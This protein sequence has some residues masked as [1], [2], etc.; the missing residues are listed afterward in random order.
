MKNSVKLA[1]AVLAMALA[2]GSADA[3]VY[4]FS[5]IGQ[6]NFD[7]TGRFTTDAS[8]NITSASGT[9]TSAG[10][11]ASGAF[12]F[13]GPGAGA[14][15]SEDWSNTYNSTSQIFTGN[16]LGI[17]ISGQFASLYNG[18]SAGYSLCTGT[19]LSVQYAPGALWNPGDLGKLTVTGVPEFST[20]AMM[21]AGFAGL[22]FVGYRRQ[23][24]VRA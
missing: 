20:W 10:P 22:G 18:V 3:A 21:L 1:A 23:K 12:T 2:A 16:G 6:T 13:T 15:G 7:V 8:N 4:D 19:C 9:V 11:Y 24:P 5:F 14:G 17:V